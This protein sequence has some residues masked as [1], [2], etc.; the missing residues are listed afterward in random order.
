LQKFDL[1]LERAN[2]KELQRVYKAL[3]QIEKELQVKQK[4]IVSQLK[5]LGDLKKFQF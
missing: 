2:E 4:E 1:L 3:D 5:D